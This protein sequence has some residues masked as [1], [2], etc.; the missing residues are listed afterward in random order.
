MDWFGFGFDGLVLVEGTWE[1]VPVLPPPIQT[2]DQREAE[3]ICGS[4]LDRVIKWETEP[5]RGISCCL[6]PLVPHI[7]G[8]M[9]FAPEPSTTDS[10]NIHKIMM[11]LLGSLGPY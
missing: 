8:R 5:I 6:C 11:R 7:A 10:G 4:G 2:T 3:L 1:T 9:G